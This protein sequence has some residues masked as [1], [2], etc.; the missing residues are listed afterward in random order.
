MKRLPCLGLL[1]QEG[2]ESEE[3]VFEM[4]FL[5]PKNVFD[6]RL[7]CWWLKHG[8][9][10]CGVDEVPTTALAILYITGLENED[11]DTGAGS[12]GFR[13][14][15]RFTSARASWDETGFLLEASS[16]LCLDDVVGEASDIVET[17]FDH[18]NYLY[19]LE[20]DRSMDPAKEIALRQGSAATAQL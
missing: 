13:R 16:E 5:M 9:L 2:G 7:K 8:G 6:T 12:M 1:G 17:F 18:A 14:T 3:V 15:L 4:V 10:G 11:S 19:R 20:E